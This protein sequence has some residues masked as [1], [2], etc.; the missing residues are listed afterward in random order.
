MLSTSALYRAL[1]H[2]AYLLDQ[3]LEALLASLLGYKRK[4]FVVTRLLFQKAAALLISSKF[5][6]SIKNFISFSPSGN[7]LLPIIIGSLNNTFKKRG[8][9]SPYQL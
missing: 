1:Y 6:E 4:G 2:I 7:G 5:A 9:T 8:F 3:I